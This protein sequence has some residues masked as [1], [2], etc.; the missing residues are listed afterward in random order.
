MTAILPLAART[1]EITAI[2]SLAAKTVLEMTAILSLAD[3]SVR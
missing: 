2:L 3:K 1:F